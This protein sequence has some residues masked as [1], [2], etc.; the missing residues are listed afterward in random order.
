MPIN[1]QGYVVDEASVENGDQDNPNVFPDYPSLH[2]PIGSYVFLI[3]N[4]IRYLE[5]IYSISI[6]SFITDWRF[7]VETVEEVLDFGPL[8]EAVTSTLDFGLITS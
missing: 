6:E 1:D 3:T 2:L 4:D 7:I 5:T 8:G